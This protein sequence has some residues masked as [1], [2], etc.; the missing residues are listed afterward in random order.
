MRCPYC[1]HNVRAT[2]VNYADTLQGQ[3]GAAHLKWAQGCLGNTRLSYPQFM[4]G[5]EP[6]CCPP[7]GGVKA[8]SPFLVRFPGR[9]S[10]RVVT[11]LEAPPPQSQSSSSLLSLRPLSLNPGSQ[12]VPCCCSTMC[13]AWSCHHVIH[14]NEAH[15]PGTKTSAP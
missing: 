4:G 2:H 13:L 11:L 5:E 9:V 7:A 15:W 10:S 14:E 8:F 12:T 6:M 1:A 3:A